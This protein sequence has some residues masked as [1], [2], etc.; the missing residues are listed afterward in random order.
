MTTLFD[1]K[2]I[3]IGMQDEVFLK[4]ETTSGTAVQ[5]AGS[6]VIR[7]TST[8]TAEQPMPFTTDPQR[9]LTFSRRLRRKGRVQAGT[10]GFDFLLKP[11]GALGVA[12]ESH[13][14]VQMG[15]GRATVNSGT[16]VQY[17]LLG[18]GPTRLPTATILIF[19]G[20]QEVKTLIGAAVDQLSLKVN[21]GNDEASLLNGTVSGMCYRIKRAGS[22]IVAEDISSSDVEIQLVAGGAKSFQDE[23]W[24]EFVRDGVKNAHGDGNGYKI[25]AVDY[26]NDTLTLARGVSAS[27]GADSGSGLLYVRPWRPT[28]V[29]SGSIVHGSI[30]DC[31]LDS[32]TLEITSLEVSI[33]NHLSMPNDVK[34]GSIYPTRHTRTQKREV[35][36]QFEVYLDPEQQRWFQDH[37]QDEGLALDCRITNDAPSALDEVKIAGPNLKLGFPGDAG[38][39]EKKRSIAFEMH[40]TSSFEDELTVDILAAA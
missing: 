4:I 36:G 15:L 7:V 14:L 9:R 37:W 6:D 12:P 8:P 23:C 25:T 38:D 1:S 28:A 18:P 39:E 40:S 32:Q 29:E 5:P 30:G 16:D 31:T 13:E 35:G 33:N 11:N 24:V 2:S 21:A 26:D 3:P 22:A 10:W 17:R 20:D 27:L 19:T 34:N